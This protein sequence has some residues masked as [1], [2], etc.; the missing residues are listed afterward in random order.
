MWD[1]YFV[2]GSGANASPSDGCGMVIV[3]ADASAEGF[4]ATDAMSLAQLRSLGQTLS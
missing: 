3:F 4:S 1:R 2:H